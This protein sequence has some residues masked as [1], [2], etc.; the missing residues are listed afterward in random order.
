MNDVV[1]IDVREAGSAIDHSLECKGISYF[2]YCTDLSNDNGFEKKNLFHLICQ[3]YINQMHVLVYST[4]YID[5]NMLI[6]YIGVLP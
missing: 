3:I 1:S 6:C 2:V 5:S 4:V